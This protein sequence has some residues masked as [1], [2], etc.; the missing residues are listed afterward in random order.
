M[1]RK[2]LA[3]ILVT[4]SFAFPW[5]VHGKDRCG[6]CAERGTVD[7]ASGLCLPA[8]IG[9]LE[10]ASFPDEIRSRARS[11]RNTVIA[12]YNG[13][14]YR[15]AVTLFLFN[16]EQDNREADLAEFKS[17]VEEILATHKGARLEQSG[18]GT[19]PVAGES[20]EAMGGWFSWEEGEDAHGSFLWIVPREN[21]YLKFRATY[22]RPVGEEAVAMKAAMDAVNQIA[23]NVCLDH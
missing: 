4:I 1:I 19:L 21:R 20:A 2:S 13:A 8:H 15:F 5:S 3:T 22:L 6:A 14:Q 23:S 18:M 7:P 16:R 17:A 10:F 12:G 9:A 11:Y